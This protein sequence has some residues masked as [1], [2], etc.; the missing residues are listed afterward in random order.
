[1]QSAFIQKSLLH[2]MKLVAAS[3]SLNSRD[4]LLP[5]RCRPC[6]AGTLGPSIDQNR[7]SATLTLSTSVLG[8]RQVKVLAQDR[9][10]AGL[11]ISVDRESAS[12]DRK[13]N[14]SHWTTPN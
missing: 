7:A 4:A 13:M 2:G 10:K 9:E 8:S 11:R 12:V 3:Q 1:L 5:N 14:G 6:H